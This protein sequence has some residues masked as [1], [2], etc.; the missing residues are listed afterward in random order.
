MKKAFMTLTAVFA[1]SLTGL[2]SACPVVKGWVG[3][4]LMPIPSGMEPECGMLYKSFKQGLTG[5]PDIRWS[6]LYTVNGNYSAIGGK[7]EKSIL[8]KGFIRLMTKDISDTTKQLGYINPTSKKILL[9]QL[10]GMGGEVF[11]GVLGN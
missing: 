6:E 2:S 4:N 11:V 3:K 10:M 8:N 7:L 9:V 1:L 5:N